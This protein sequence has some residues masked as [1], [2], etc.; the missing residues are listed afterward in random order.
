M[1]QHPVAAQN[2][3]GT[4]ILQHNSLY[5]APSRTLM[6]ADI[7]GTFAAFDRGRLMAITDVYDAPSH[8][9]SYHPSVGESLVTAGDGGVYFGPDL[10]SL[11]HIGE[12]ERWSVLA[13]SLQLVSPLT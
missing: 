5:P 7:N 6:E 9:R 10:A 3:H 13:K 12:G 2:H 4:T 11:V 8:A 1:K